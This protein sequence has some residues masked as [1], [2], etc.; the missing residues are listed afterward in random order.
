M[1]MMFQTL[2]LRQTPACDEARVRHS[3]RLKPRAK[4]RTSASPGTS[5]CHSQLDT[6]LKFARHKTRQLAELLSLH[7]FLA[8]DA[9]SS[10]RKLT[11]SK[12]TI[13]LHQQTESITSVHISFP[14]DHDLARQEQKCI[15]A[16]HSFLIVRP[17]HAGTAE[18]K[19]AYASLR[20]TTCSQ[21]WSRLPTPGP[22]DTSCQHALLQRPRGQRAYTRRASIRVLHSEA[23]EG[24]QNHILH[25][26][27][28]SQGSRR[29]C[30]RQA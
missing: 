18:K 25:T 15:A 28:S 29:F 16:P 2:G 6:S 7:I 4:A 19:A 21:R 14:L 11:H 20:A 1:R 12:F 23:V 26:G 30:I 24:R 13:A 27:T 5:L 17:R 9:H 22:T 3:G 8:T 10:A